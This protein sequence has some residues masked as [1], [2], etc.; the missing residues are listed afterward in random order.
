MF[1]PGADVLFRDVDVDT[2]N[3]S[4]FF[5]TYSTWKW[6]VNGYKKPGAFTE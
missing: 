1:G 2:P 4:P 6:F 5:F 3:F